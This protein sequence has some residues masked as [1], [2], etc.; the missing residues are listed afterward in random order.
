M[1]G[2][3]LFPVLVP[4]GNFALVWGG[5]MLLI[6]L[7]QAVSV[8]FLL[9]FEV[10]DSDVMLGLDFACTLAFFADILVSFNTSFYRKGRLVTD[11]KAICERYAC[12]W[13][14]LDVLSSLPY[15]WL[16]QSPFESAPSDR[17]LM[18]LV[19]V[20]RMLRAFRLA[21]LI[22][23]KKSL[24]L[25]QQQLSDTW[26]VFFTALSLCLLLISLAH[27]AACVFRYAAAFEPG[28][29]LQAYQDTDLLEQYVTTVY[30]ATTTLTTTGY[31]DVV[32]LATQERIYG[33]VIMVLSAGVFS[34]LIGKIGTLITL[35][36]QDK[37]EQQER[38]MTASSF[39]K[40]AAVH[41]E[42]AYRAL[43]Y[44]DY[45]WETRK[46]RTVLDRSLLQLLSEPLKNQV[47]QHIFG[48]V[49]L[50]AP[51]LGFFGGPFISQLARDVRTDIFAQDDVIFEQGQTSTTFYFLE[52][53]CIEVFLKFHTLAVLQPGQ[54][55]GEL[56]FFSA[57]PRTAS[58]RCLHFA[59]LIS[60]ARSSLLELVAQHPKARYALQQIQDRINAKEYGRVGISCYLCSEHSHLAAVCPAVLLTFDRK[61]LARRWARSRSLTLRQQASLQAGPFFRRERKVRRALH[62]SLSNVTSRAGQSVLT[63]ALRRKAVRSKDWGSAVEEE[64]SVMTL[65][66]VAESRVEKTR[67]LS[68]LSCLEQPRRQPRRR[69]VVN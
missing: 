52:K 33:T 62:Y 14:A 40:T 37:S 57:Q 25:L 29:W 27:W 24:N 51:A 48:T 44:V 65:P 67:R 56:A 61:A 64:D 11:R 58:V 59:E 41:S 43:R 69:L 2:L 4:D 34:Y 8:P 20:A 53:G 18:R 45:V 38:V 63:A 50:R 12:S 36:E 10:P 3:R 47:C 6:V 42:V 22:K 13:L 30:W 66:E 19:T 15:S 16:L 7:Y 28:S 39:L 49:L 55:F 9:A 23:M 17:N 5:L 60:L 54:Y 46:R 31:G 1:G 21:R 35:L 26:S 32:P 68:L